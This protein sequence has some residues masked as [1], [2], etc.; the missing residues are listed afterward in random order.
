MLKLS[1]CRDENT[2][3]IQNGNLHLKQNGERFNKKIIIENR[4]ANPLNRG[5]PGIGKWM[6]QL[7]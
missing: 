6:F 5:I 1:L 4:Q 2:G 3:M 7:S